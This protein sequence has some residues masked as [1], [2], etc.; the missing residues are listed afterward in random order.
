M[1]TNEK[2]IFEYEQAEKVRLAL[3]KEQERTDKAYAIKLTERA[4]FAII[5]LMGLTVAGTLIK[6]ALDYI[7]MFL[8]K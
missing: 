2:K 5:G 3:E 6:V 1:D 7:G 4:V 8:H